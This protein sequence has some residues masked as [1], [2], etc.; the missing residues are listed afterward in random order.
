MLWH[1]KVLVCAGGMLL[2]TYGHQANF[3]SEKPN[4][5]PIENISANTVPNT[6]LHNAENVYACAH[7]YDVIYTNANG[8]QTLRQGGSRAWRNNNPGCIRSGQFAYQNGAIGHAGGFAVFPDEESGLNAICALLR[9]DK[10]NNKTIAA[11]IYSYAPPCENNTVAYNNYLCKLTG[12][13]TS[14]KICDLNDEQIKRL[15]YAIKKIEGW[16]EGSEKLIRQDTINATTQ[17]PQ[18]TR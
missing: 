17:F 15:A 4:Y 10:Y 12:L 1:Y 18:H 9:T 2:S 7:Q 13:S 11:A 8:A 3:S 6:N 5:D 14:L 16:R